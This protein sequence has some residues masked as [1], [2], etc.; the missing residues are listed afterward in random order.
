MRVEGKSAWIRHAPIVQEGLGDA[1]LFLRWQHMTRQYEA[2]FAG[3]LA[4][5][6]PHA[7]TIPGDISNTA[8]PWSTY[9]PHSHAAP[10]I[11][12]PPGV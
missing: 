4:L 9:I 2:Q 8:L 11:P 7:E 12:P 3:H 5:H 6:L 10:H 1:A